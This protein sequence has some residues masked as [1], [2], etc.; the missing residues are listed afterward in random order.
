ML[1]KRQNK[2]PG[3]AKY[4]DTIDKEQYS[5]I[6]RDCLSDKSETTTISESINIIATTMAKRINSFLS[7]KFLAKSSYTYDS[8]LVPIIIGKNLN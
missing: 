8:W 3:N 4:H 2:Q 7:S 6:R 1:D 5:C